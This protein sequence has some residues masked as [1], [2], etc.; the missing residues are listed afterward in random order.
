[1]ARHLMRCEHADDSAR[2][3]D[4]RSY[5]SLNN[6]KKEIKS[7]S[8]DSTY[9]RKKS[10]RS[11]GDFSKVNNYNQSSIKNASLFLK[12]QFKFLSNLPRFRKNLSQLECENRLD[13]CSI[14]EAIK[15]MHNGATFPLT[16]TVFIII[17]HDGI[18]QPQIWQSFFEISHFGLVVYCSNIFQ[19]SLTNFFRNY[20]IPE[21]MTDFN[22][23]GD[24]VPT[25]LVLMSRALMMYPNLKKAC[26]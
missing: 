2:N 15:D 24:V 17:A 18:K 16:T 23:Y 6:T 10:R 7:E 8:D 25:I 4:V 20:L 22:G 1:M 19:H 11:N 9:S 26:N 12:E 3:S 21:D 5:G 13:T 14:T